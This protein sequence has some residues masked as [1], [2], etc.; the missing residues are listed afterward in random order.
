M[1]STCFCPTRIGLQ[2]HKNKPVFLFFNVGSEDSILG[3][4]ACRQAFLPAQFPPQQ[5]Y[6]FQGLPEMISTGT[7]VGVFVHLLLSSG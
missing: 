1:V 5:Q 6:N 3:P 4:C 2:A 7:C